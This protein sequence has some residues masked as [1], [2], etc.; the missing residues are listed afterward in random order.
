MAKFWISVPY[1][2][3]K[4]RRKEMEGEP[5]TISKHKFFTFKNMFNNYIVTE[6]H[7]GA[8]LVQGITRKIAIKEARR[9]IKINGVEKLEAKIAK[10]PQVKNLPIL[11]YPRDCRFLN[12]PIAHTIAMA[13]PSEVYG[14]F[15]DEF[16]AFFNYEN[17]GITR[18]KMEELLKASW[19]SE[20]KEYRDILKSST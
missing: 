14:E 19:D 2:D 3:G 20:M 17:P 1:Y 8:K 5:V 12:D 10:L 15:P 6:I 4:P 18:E 7:T 9:I 13:H 16:W 11:E